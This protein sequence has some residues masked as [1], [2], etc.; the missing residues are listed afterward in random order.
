MTFPKP[1]PVPVS[2]STKDTPQ[3]IRNLVASPELSRLDL[4]SETEHSLVLRASARS[5]V[6]KAAHQ[7][8]RLGFHTKYKLTEDKTNWD[9]FLSYDTDAILIN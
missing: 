8:R 5:D 7:A 9:L 1:N 4:I 6:A 3:I 2:Y